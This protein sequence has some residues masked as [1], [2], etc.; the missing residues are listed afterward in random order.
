MTI[1]NDSPASICTQ[2]VYFRAGSRRFHPAPDDGSAGIPRL[3]ALD[4]TTDPAR[5]QRPANV[6][7]ARG[8]PFDLRPAGRN[9]VA[10]EPFKPQ[11]I[12]ENAGQRPGSCAPWTP[13][14]RTS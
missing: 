9:N 6:A 13:I 10:A 3:G 7:P 4:R 14:R 8:F 11:S 5:R 2:S 12:L 1:I